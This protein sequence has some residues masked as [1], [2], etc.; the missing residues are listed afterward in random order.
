MPPT[1]MSKIEDR[2]VCKIQEAQ[3]EAMDLAVYL[4]KLI[5]IAEEAHRIKASASES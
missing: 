3:Q 5:D 4:E 1:I 2:V